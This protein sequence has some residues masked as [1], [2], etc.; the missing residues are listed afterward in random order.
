MA[1]YAKVLLN[2][3]SN[4]KSIVV[5]SSGSSG[6]TIIHTSVAG[7][8]DK[9]EIWIYAMNT[10]EDY[11]DLSLL[12]GG[13][14]HPDDLIRV[15]IPPSAGPVLVIPGWILNGANIV[16]AYAETANV[17]TLNGFVN[18]IYSSGS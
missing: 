14:V 6:A 4:G 1:S 18:R 7:S 5:D 10:D 15:T 11:Q 2:G 8:N 17:L 9:D 12:W 16:K 3:G 13:T